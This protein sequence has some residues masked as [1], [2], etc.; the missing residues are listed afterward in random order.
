V[1]SSRFNFHLLSSSIFHYRAILS[2]DD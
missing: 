1:I 2:G